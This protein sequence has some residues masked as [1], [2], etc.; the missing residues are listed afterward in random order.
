MSPL[1]TLLYVTCVAAI[2]SSS[3]A[4]DAQDADKT[5]EPLKVEFSRAFGAPADGSWD[6][7]FSGD[8]IQ[9]PIKY[10]TEKP[11]QTI[12]KS[13]QYALSSATSGNE[14]WYGSAAS[15]WCYWPYVSMKM[16]VTL[17]NHE[18]PS[19]GCQMTPP[20]GQRP[21][22][23][24]YFHNVVTNVTTHVGPDTIING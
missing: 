7:L 14:I 21:T 15:V 6:G 16:P 10:A 17:M 24:I 8:N 5:T 2:A 13:A 9:D 4:M 19:H 18:T 22:A 23:Q 1:K 11:E 3:L 20:S 12:F